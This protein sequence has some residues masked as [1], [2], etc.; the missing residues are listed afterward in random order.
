M[1]EIQKHAKSGR[2]IWGDKETKLEKAT[3]TES[4]KKRD[5]DRRKARDRDGDTETE[6]EFPG[7]E[8]HAG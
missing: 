3:E 1:I 6:T 2:Q 8:K 5:R 7:W 4:G